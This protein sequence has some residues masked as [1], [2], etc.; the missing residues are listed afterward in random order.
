MSTSSSNRPIQSKHSIVKK[1]V[2]Q[3]F[4]ESP[5]ETIALEKLQGFIASIDAL[6]Q[7]NEL[8]IGIG[9]AIHAGSLVLGVVDQSMRVVVWN[10]F[11]AKTTGITQDEI[12]GKDIIR[13]VPNLLMGS[14]Q[15][16]FRAAFD[17]CLKGHPVHGSI[18]QMG[19]KDGATLQMLCNFSPLITP[20]GTDGVI[21]IAH[22]VT[23]M[24][25]SSISS[26]TT[27]E[28]PNV[29]TTSNGE[30]SELRLLVC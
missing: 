2:E 23:H 3:A 30:Q 28:T 9:K 21:L 14:S 1:L 5:G 24:G 13:E 17:Q 4:G 18:L 10:T 29:A 27:A 20:R 15:V 11:A 6:F 26:A 25:G 22:D 8:P 7:N 16:S 12:K 19:R